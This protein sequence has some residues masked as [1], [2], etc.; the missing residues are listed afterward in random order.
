MTSESSSLPFV[1]F[2]NEELFPWYNRPFNYF[3]PLKK[4]HR[5]SNDLIFDKFD[6]MSNYF[7]ELDELEELNDAR[8]SLN[9]DIPQDNSNNA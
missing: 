6:K 2:L 5:S 7:I 3:V 8:F 1:P 4:D 9:E